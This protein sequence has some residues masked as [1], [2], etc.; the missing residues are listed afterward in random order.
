[1]CIYIY[2]LKNTFQ[3]LHWDDNKRCFNGSTM[4]LCEVKKK[5]KKRR[6]EFLGQIEQRIDRN[7]G[8]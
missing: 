5:K 2:I 4:H 6:E 8:T 1:M 7:M 3:A